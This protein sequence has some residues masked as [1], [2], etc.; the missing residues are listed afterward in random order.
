MKTKINYNELKRFCVLNRITL[1]E[2]S[3]RTGIQYDRAHRLSHS[4]RLLHDLK[5]SELG[6]ITE[7][8]PDFL[9]NY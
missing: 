1:K 2:F 6:K 9:L 5:V 3:E 4:R 7:A 8:Y